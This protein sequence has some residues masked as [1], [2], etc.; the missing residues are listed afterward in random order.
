MKSDKTQ[1]IISTIENILEEKFISSQFAID[2]FGENIDYD[3]DDD[4]EMGPDGPKI[5]VLITINDVPE[6]RLSDV[7]KNYKNY[8]FA[9]S[10]WGKKYDIILDTIYTD[11]EE[12]TVTISFDAYDTY[13]YEKY[14]DL[15]KTILTIEQAAE[16]A[17]ERLEINNF[18]GEENDHI[19]QIKKAIKSGT[20]QAI[21]KVLKQS[22]HWIGMCNIEHSEDQFNSSIMEA[23]SRSNIKAPSI[24]EREEIIKKAITFP[25][26]SKKEIEAINKWDFADGFSI[27]NPKEITKELI[28]KDPVEMYAL[29]LR[30]GSDFLIDSS[31]DLYKMKDS[32]DYAFGKEI[33]KRGKKIGKNKDAGIPIV[34]L[35]NRLLTEPELNYITK[36]GIT[37]SESA[38]DDAPDSDA[39]NNIVILNPWVK[40]IDAREMKAILIDSMGSKK[41]FEYSVV[42]ELKDYGKIT[43]TNKTNSHDSSNDKTSELQNN[44]NILLKLKYGITIEDAG[45]D[46]VFFN[47]AVINNESPEEIVSAH[48]EKYELT[49]ISSDIYNNGGPIASEIKYKCQLKD[50]KG[51]VIGDYEFSY[52]EDDYA[53]KSLQ[54]MG[55]EMH[56]GDTINWV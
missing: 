23:I 6:Y 47:Q 34:Y 27:V 50:R 42:R 33:A 8:E 39:S 40:K 29:D 32:G 41:E 20:P 53:K 45:M 51:N 15:D 10:A 48:A 11:E 13:P 18:G 36:Q 1:K 30:D 25:G 54:A 37:I 2:N 5:K 26:Y 12:E 21:L 19:R 44:V 4:Q 56:I 52:K 55:V 9:I 17:I 14:E 22:I 28:I 24:V 46:D 49:P 7:S 38:Y 31:H 43:N 16:L 35:L 3:L